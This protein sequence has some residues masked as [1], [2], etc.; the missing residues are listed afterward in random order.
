MY[1]NFRNDIV[2]NIVNIQVQCSLLQ[3]IFQNRDKW[4]KI[5]CLFSRK[6]KNYCL[7]SAFTDV[8]SI[9]LA[10]SSGII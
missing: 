8:E 10:D 5:C 7:Y 1:T 3:Q 4:G 6:K 2:N 9:A